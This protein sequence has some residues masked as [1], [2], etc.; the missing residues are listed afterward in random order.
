MEL[1]E[2]LSHREA[3]VEELEL[4]TSRFVIQVLSVFPLSHV[5]LGKITA[6]K[7]FNFLYEHL[8]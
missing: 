2:E 8:S 5:F 3:E 4:K 1:L 7:L 6:N